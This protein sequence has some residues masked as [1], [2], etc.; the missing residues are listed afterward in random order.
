M[1]ALL[2]ADP[3]KLSPIQIIT[4][5]ETHHA[6]YAYQADNQGQYQIQKTCHYDTAAGISR[7]V[8]DAHGGVHAG[9]QMCYGRKSTQE[10]E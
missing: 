1:E 5:P 8:I 3:A 4:G 2:M 6:L 9:I 7:F 10:S